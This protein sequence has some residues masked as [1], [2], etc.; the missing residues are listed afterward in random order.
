MPVPETTSAEAFERYVGG[1]C[2]RVGRGEVWR[3]VKAWI[4]ALPPEIDTLHLPSVSETSP[5]L[6]C[7]EKAVSVAI[8]DIDGDWMEKVYRR[9]IVPNWDKLYQKPGYAPEK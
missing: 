8:E 6:Y 9:D 7:E 1:K 5:G 4:I 2:V 3:E